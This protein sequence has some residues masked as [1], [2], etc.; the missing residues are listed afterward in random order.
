[1]LLFAAATKVMNPATIARVLLWDGVPQQ[2]L[3]GAIWTVVLAE[4]IVAAL[5]L[6]W[7]SRIVIALTML[8]FVAFTF[9]LIKLY[10]DPTAPGCGCMTISRAMG[11]AASSEHL[12]GIVR[13]SAILASGA[14]A[15]CHRGKERS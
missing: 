3:R 7:A 12:T 11:R 10:R 6:V 4:V 8:V 9:Q 13:N 2:Y 15:L 14:F 5:L 1:M